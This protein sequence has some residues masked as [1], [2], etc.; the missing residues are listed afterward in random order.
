MAVAAGMV[1][2]TRRSEK[3]G[4]TTPGTAERLARCVRANGL[5]DGAEI[6][7]DTL[8]RH[9]VMDKKASAERI[10]IIIAKRVGESFV[11]SLSLK[12]Y[13]D[14]VRGCYENDTTV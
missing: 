2:L 7:D 6:D 11:K 14:F 8:I 1:M 12:D 5:P 10:N 4:L 13:A 3:Y 9:S